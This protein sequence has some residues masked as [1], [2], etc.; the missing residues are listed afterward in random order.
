MSAQ[1]TDFV[2][3]GV[4]FRSRWVQDPEHVNGGH[5]ERVSACGRIVCRRTYGEPW[6]ELTVDGGRK[7]ARLP[8]MKAAMVAG[9]QTL[10]RIKLS[11][12]R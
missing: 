5:F 1:D 10:N 12:A 2:C 9:L 8:T 4:T 11:A 6:H 7:V 3:Q